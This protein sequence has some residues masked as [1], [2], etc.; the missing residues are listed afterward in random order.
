MTTTTKRRSASP[1][2]ASTSRRQSEPAWAEFSDEQLLDTRICDLGLRIEGTRLEQRIEQLYD[3]LSTRDLHFRPHCWLSDEWFTPDGIPGIAIPFYLAHSRLERLE[4]KQMLEVEG[5]SKASCMRILRH[6]AGHAI[7]NAYRLGRRQSWQRIF[8]RSSQPY[9]EHYSP[10]PYSKSY[11]QHLD[12][13]YAQAHPAEDFAETFAVWVRPR[14]PW[15]AQYNG[16]PALKKLEYV[17][18]LMVDVASK[19]QQVASRKRMDPVRTLKK[20]LRE[21]YDEKKERYGVGHP[22]VY[23]RDLLKLFSE[24]PEHSSNLAA[25]VVLRANRR[26]LRQAIGEWTGQYQYTIDQVLNEMID[27]CRELRLR[28]RR[29]ERHTRRDLLVMLTVQTMNYLHGGNHRVAL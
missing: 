25:A 24:A 20:T 21:H 28:L 9:P 1:K 17:D 8:G 13:W 16:W 3:E 22:T 12:M 29:S 19:K 7:D 6:E 26:Y 15:R 4:R 10:K 14:S 27:R 18:K 11:V 5:G 23:D 2:R